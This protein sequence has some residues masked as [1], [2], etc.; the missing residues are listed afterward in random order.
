MKKQK[1]I[2]LAVLSILLIC[3]N[4]WS[5]NLLEVEGKLTIPLNTLTINVHGNFVEN[6][7]D[8]QF[9]QDAATKAYVDNLLLSFGVSIGPSGIQGLLNS[10][11]SPATIL[12]NGAALTDFI[13]LNHAGGIIFYMEPSGNGTGLVSAASDQ[14]TGA[15]WGCFGT[16]ITGADGTIIGTGNQN[17]ID[18]E[19]GCTTS[20]TA[21]DICANLSL[22]G[23]TDWFLPSKDEL[24][25]MYTKI[26]QA[27]AAPNT[28]IG[29]FADSFY[30][31][32]SEFDANLA[33]EQDFD[34]GVQGNGFKYLNDHVRAI[35]AF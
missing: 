25:E 26:G 21:A 6:V 28:N 8:P 7:A 13:G 15:E 16:P 20:S 1:I 27:A 14:S 12:S 4:S 10:G 24:N 9:A 22:N 11:Y 30:W 23:F 3:Q 19:A 32:S 29:N 35:R 2:F 18:I 17:T 31:S 33:W 5:Q 34:D